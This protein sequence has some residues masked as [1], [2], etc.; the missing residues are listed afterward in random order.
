MVSFSPYYS[1]VNGVGGGMN[2][3]SIKGT[4]PEISTG[5]KVNGRHF[6]YDRRSLLLERSPRV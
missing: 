3:H 6:Y 4:T 2:N 1:P 5:L